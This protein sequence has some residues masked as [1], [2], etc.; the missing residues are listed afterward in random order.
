M[1]SIKFQP[2]SDASNSQCCDKRCD[3]FSVTS[4]D[5][6]PS[7]ELQKCI[8]DEVSQLVNMLIVVAKHLAVL[9]RRNYWRYIRLKRV[10]DDSI[11]VITSVSQQILSLKFGD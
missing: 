7:F 6:A 5:T 3:I 10:L 9:L 11:G 4:R 8:L 1:S 2:K